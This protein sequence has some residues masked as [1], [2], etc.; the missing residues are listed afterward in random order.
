MR[1]LI[2]DM[3]QSIYLIQMKKREARQAK[4][5]AQRIER[6]KRRGSSSRPTTRSPPRATPRST[7]KIREH[8]R[9]AEKKGV[10]GAEQGVDGQAGP[11]HREALLAV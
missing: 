6:K 1:R 8:R 3:E 7:G 2:K 9:A 11:A 4:E 10:G 5:K